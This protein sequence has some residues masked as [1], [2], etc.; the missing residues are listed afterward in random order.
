M[1][2]AIK[3]T[4]S[5]SHFKLI[6]LFGGPIL[7]LF[8]LLTEPPAGMSPDAWK[9]AGIALMMAAWWISEALPL[10]ATALLPLVLFPLLDIISIKQAAGPY[11][12]PAIFLFMGGFIIAIAMERW[13]LHK[14]IAL[15]IIRVIGTGSTTVVAG[16]MVATAFLSMWISNTA[17][18]VMMLPISMSVISS[19]LERAEGAGAKDRHRFALAMMLGIAYSASIGGIS[20]LVG[21]PPNAVFKGFMLTTYGFDINFADWM[22]IGLPFSLTMLVLTWLALTKVLF[23]CNLGNIAGGADMIRDELNKLGPMK[24]AEKVVAVVFTMTAFLWIFQK[25]IKN[26]FEG[27]SLNDAT[28]AIFGALLLFLIPTNLKESKFVM[29]WKEAE[30]LPWGVLI[31]FGGG[32]SLASALNRTGLAGWIGNEIAMMGQ[33]ELV[34]LILMVVTII[35]FLTELMSNVATVTAFL[36]VIAAVAIGFGEN[37]LILVIP[38][39]IA[40]S[41]AFMMPVA[42]PPNAIVFGSGHVKIAEM[43]KA[44]WAL[45]LIAIILITVLMYFVVQPVFEITR[46]EIPEWAKAPPP[47][48]AAQ[49]MAPPRA[50]QPAQATPSQGEQPVRLAPVIGKP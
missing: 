45:N 7:L 5:Y 15:N 19:I 10:S 4:V 42:T 20:T 48:A 39:T 50:P 17:T 24:W 44:G 30:R 49:Q 40:A 18:V 37:P 25:P 36:P 43:I 22:M 29:S 26:A 38:A 27:L 3:S 41:C 9:T 11:A 34:L 21:T 35:V 46:K 14:R 8:T 16:F 32:L 33:I 23:R 28:V 31:L 12:S 47:P 2:E 13:G 1:N 6:G